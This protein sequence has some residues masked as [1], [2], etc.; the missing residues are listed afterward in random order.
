[1]RPSLGLTLLTVVALAGPAL[2]QVDPGPIVAAERA[3]AADGL[4][5]GVKI[6]FLAHSSPEAIVMQPGPIN[7]HASLSAQPDPKPGE[8]QPALFWWPLWAGIARSG[9]LGFTSGP[10]SVDGE[11][12][13]YYFTIWKKQP[14]DGWKWVF[15]GGGLGDAKAEPAAGTEPVRVPLAAAASGS[16]WAA[17]SEIATVEAELAARAKSDQKAAHL[18]YLAPG[19]RIYVPREPVARDRRTLEAQL[20]AYPDSITFELLR[21]E[22]SSAGDLAWTYGSAEWAR[23]GQGR[24]GHYVRVWQKHTD[25]WKLTFAQILPMP[26][27]AAP[28]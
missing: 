12:G 14:D 17:M 19:G 27:S 6:S 3:F 22:A 25:G 13:G 5:S 15:D 28:G 7:A 16:A 21:G 1:M 8:K 24:R 18:A 20:G 2:A 4:K 9:D 11:R 10:I 26:P 23:D